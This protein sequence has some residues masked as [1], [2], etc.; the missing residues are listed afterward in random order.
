MPHGQLALQQKCLCENACGKDAYGKKCWSR[1]IT[2]L[3]TGVFDECRLW[4]GCVVSHLMSPP[5]EVGGE[6]GVQRVWLGGHGGM[7]SSQWL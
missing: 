7:L 6:P 4:T 3:D 5:S 2:A 1:L